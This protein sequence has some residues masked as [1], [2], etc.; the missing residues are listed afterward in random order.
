LTEKLPAHL[1]V[2]VHRVENGQ[3]TSVPS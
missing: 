1:G 3:V 2:L